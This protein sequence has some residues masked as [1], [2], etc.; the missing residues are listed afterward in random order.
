MNR[1]GNS[2]QATAFEGEQQ[3]GA[4][5]CD[6]V[7]AAVPILELLPN[8]IRYQQMLQC[9]TVISN[10]TERFNWVRAAAW[11]NRG[12]CE[13][14]GILVLHWHVRL[15]SFVDLAV[16]QSMMPAVQITRRS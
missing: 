9:W 6:I 7:L 4:V 12:T 11:Y 2:S 16:L 13:R 1:Q 10:L 15:F 8:R 14:L 5:P 3:C